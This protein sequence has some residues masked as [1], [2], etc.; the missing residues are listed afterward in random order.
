M[1]KSDPNVVCILPFLHQVLA[2]VEGYIPHE[3]FNEQTRPLVATKQ[4][5]HCFAL[6]TGA[7]RMEPQVFFLE[8]KL[9][10]YIIYVLI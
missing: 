10:T 4:G 7:Q 5:F 9:Y 1:R 2:N 3:D 8:E 6:T